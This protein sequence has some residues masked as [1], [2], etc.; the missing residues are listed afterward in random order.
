VHVNSQFGPLQRD[1]VK[2]VELCIP[3]L[4]FLP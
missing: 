3:S 2:E 4:K 1:T